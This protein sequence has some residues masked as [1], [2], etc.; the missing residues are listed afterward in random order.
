M[1]QLLTTIFFLFS[2]SA[3]SQQVTNTVILDGSDSKAEIGS[4][5]KYQWTQTSGTAT[6]IASPNADTTVVTFT[7]PGNYE[8]RL[9]VTDAKGFTGSSYATVSVGQY[10]APKAVIKVTRFDILLPPKQ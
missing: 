1:K 6:V 3:F 5:V 2:F 9:T 8:Y 4:I 7:A 10:G